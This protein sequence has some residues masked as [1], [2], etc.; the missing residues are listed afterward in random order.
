VSFR[1]ASSFLALSNRDL[2]GLAQRRSPFRADRYFNEEPVADCQE[3]I[4]VVVAATAFMAIARWSINIV[5]SIRAHKGAEGIVAIGFGCVRGDDDAI[6]GLY[7]Y[8][9]ALVV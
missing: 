8:I 4:P 9:G 1:R 5:R 2:S 6:L 3:L 7:D